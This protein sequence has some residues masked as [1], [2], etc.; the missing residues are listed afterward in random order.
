M[1]STFHKAY[2]FLFTDKESEVFKRL[3]HCIHSNLKEFLTLIA[4]FLALILGLQRVL[5][6]ESVLVEP[7]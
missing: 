2:V 3:T 5:V 4:S 6:S 7:H 1:F